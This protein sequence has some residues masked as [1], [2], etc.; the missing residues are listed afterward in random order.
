M[1]IKPSNVQL[2]PHIY[3]RAAVFTPS[4]PVT[5]DFL[6]DFDAK[7]LKMTHPLSLCHF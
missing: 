2:Q 5:A 3:S 1:M 6:Q 4:H 7:T